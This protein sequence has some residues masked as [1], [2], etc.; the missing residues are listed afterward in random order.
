[1]SK[2]PSMS[3]ANSVWNIAGTLAGP[4]VAALTDEAL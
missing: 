2:S 1:M 3:A 4:E